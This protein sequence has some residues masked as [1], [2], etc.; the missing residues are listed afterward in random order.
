MSDGDRYFKTLNEYLVEYDSSK[1]DTTTHDGMKSTLYY[2]TALEKD[3]ISISKYV[4][5][6]AKLKEFGF[7]SFEQ[8]GEFVS[9]TIDGMLDNCYGFAY[10][11]SGSSPKVLKCGLVVSWKR[12]YRNWYY[13]TT[14]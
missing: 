11:E 6:R 8:T 9:F 1:V 2:I 4:E 12:V 14:T 5:F 13:W 3:S 7:I 10:S